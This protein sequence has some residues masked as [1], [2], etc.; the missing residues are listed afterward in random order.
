M[1]DI[2][3]QTTLDEHFYDGKPWQILIERSWNKSITLD[4]AAFTDPDVLTEDGKFIRSGVALK[5]GVTPGLYVPATGTD[6]YVGFLESAVLLVT[7]STRSSAALMTHGAV[8]DAQVPN[9]VPTGGGPAMI[10]HDA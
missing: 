4:L 6:A 8:L 2:Q 1:V 10:R 9:G 3:P 7:G 5:V